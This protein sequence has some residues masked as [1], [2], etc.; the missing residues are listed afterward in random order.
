[1]SEKISTS[2]HSQRPDGPGVKQ[3]LLILGMNAHIDL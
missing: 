2:S 1:M 3:E